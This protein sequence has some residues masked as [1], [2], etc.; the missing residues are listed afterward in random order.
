MLLGRAISEKS[1]AISI[2]ES[3]KSCLEETTGGLL[4]PTPSWGRTTAN[5]GSGQPWLCLAIACKPPKSCMPEFLW[6]AY[7]SAILHWN[8]FFLNVQIKPLRPKPLSL[9]LCSMVKLSFDLSFFCLAASEIAVVSTQHAS[10]APLRSFH[11]TCAYGEP[12]NAL[13]QIH[14]ELCTQN[15]VQYYRCSLDSTD[16]RIIASFG[17]LGMHF[18][19]CCIIMWFALITVGMNW[20]HSDLFLLCVQLGTVT[21]RSFFC[22]LIFGLPPYSL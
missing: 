11:R 15:W 12:Y 13:F 21:P 18:L 17:R 20:W 9:V 2:Q 4:V 8:D 5:Y 22:R 6:R 1:D 16:Y 10:I 3:W 14:P 19:T 7:S